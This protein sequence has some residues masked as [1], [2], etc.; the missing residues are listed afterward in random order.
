M[1]DVTAD[2]ELEMLRIEVFV[3]ISSLKTDHDALAAAVH[4]MLG[5]LLMIESRLDHIAGMYC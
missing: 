1:V 2:T 3:E 5:R 4:E